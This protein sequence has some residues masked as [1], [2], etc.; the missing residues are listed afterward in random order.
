R[1][2]APSP[3]LADDQAAAFDA[4]ATRFGPGDLARMLSLSSELESTGSLRRSGNPR[5]VLEMLLL[6][7]SY[8]D[9][10][11]ELEELIRGL[12]G[13][14]APGGD[15]GGCVRERTGPGQPAGAGGRAPRTAP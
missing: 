10:T 6:R 2:G 3:D 11:V 5:L 8:L 1:L 4:A 13:A 12:G 14:P 7:L 9:R 15:G